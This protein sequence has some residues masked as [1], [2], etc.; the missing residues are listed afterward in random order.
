MYKRQLEGRLNERGVTLDLSDEVKQKLANEGFDELMGARPMQRVINDKLKKRLAHEM[1]DDDGKLQNG[2]H[3][4][5]TLGNKGELRFS[6]KK[7]A[8]S[9][10]DTKAG[11]GG[12]K[13][14]Q[15]GPKSPEHVV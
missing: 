1:L 2:G 13:V 4:K 7:A 5:I 6:F 10:P 11:G 9:D 12:P 8:K 3:A 14:K 15:T